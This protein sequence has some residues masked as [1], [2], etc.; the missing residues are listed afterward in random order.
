MG[1]TN[2]EKILFISGPVGLGHVGREL[3][4]AKELRKLDSNVEIVWYAEEPATE[5]LRSAGESIQW[6]IDES[7]ITTGFADTSSSDDFSLSLPNFFLRWSKTFPE[8][9]ALYQNIVKEEGVDTIVGD[10]SMEL[11]LA[12]VKHPEYKRFKFVY[13]T[14]FF[15]AYQIRMKLME[16]LA[17]YIF[18]RGWSKF[19]RN[20][21]LYE[22]FIFIGEREDIRDKSMGLFLPNRKDLANKYADFVGPILPFHP[23]DY[24]DKEEMK[25]KLGY[26]SRPLII[27]TGGGS[28]ACKPLLDLCARTYPIL[29]KNMSDVQ[30]RIVTGPRIPQEAI[31][32]GNGLSVV[33]FV[34]R[35]YEHFAAAD[36][37]ITSAG[38]A[39]TLELTALQRP[40]L[41][42]PLKYH[43]E[44][45]FEVVPRCERYSAGVKMVFSEITPELLTKSIIENIGV[46][47]NYPKVPLDGAKKTAELIRHVMG[48]R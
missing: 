22:K 43:F 7:M 4:I 1:G 2:L 34:P 37:V 45:N 15:G 3:E 47:V 13:L 16:I 5:Y 29:R 27:C 32:P 19:M 26:D 42:F 14:D 30:M 40:F 20:P 18:N 17:V 12:L 6:S 24:M 9:V 28:S 21:E 38:G 39:S 46:K 10:E 48:T 25:R 31:N 44:Q 35:L 11:M 41:Y 36:L 8:R 33:G 23:E